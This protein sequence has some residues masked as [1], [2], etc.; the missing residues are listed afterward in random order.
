MILH[1]F[2]LIYVDGFSLTRTPLV[3]RKR[4]LSELIVPL[5]DSG[6]LRYS[7]HVEGN[8]AKFFRQA[9]EFGIEGIVSKLAAQLTILSAVATGKRSNACV[10]R[11][12]SSRATPY[13]TRVFRSARSF[14][15]FTTREN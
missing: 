15:V 3:D 12:L 9:C 6:V 14:S 1:A 13:L 5:G 4:V 10:D 8:G 11:N 7:D 2:D